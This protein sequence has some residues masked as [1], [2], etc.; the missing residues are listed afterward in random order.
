MDLAAQMI[1]HAGLPCGNSIKP[2]PKFAFP[3]P[4]VT[5]RAAF[6]GGL[7]SA[8]VRRNAPA[9]V[10]FAKK[11]KEY[12][13]GPVDDFVDEMEDVVDEEDFAEDEEEGNDGFVSSGDVSFLLLQLGDLESSGV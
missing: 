5:V 8:T 9:V 12:I 6:P 4:A 10:L 11:R 3:S 1:L 7:C 13:D 2:S